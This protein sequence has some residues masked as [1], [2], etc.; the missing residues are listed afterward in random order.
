MLEWRSWIRAKGWDVGTIQHRLQ[1]VHLSRHLHWGTASRHCKIHCRRWNHCFSPSLAVYWSL[2]FT[3][4]LH[5]WSCMLAASS[6]SHSDNFQLYSWT[7]NKE[8]YASLK[9][10]YFLTSD[11]SLVQSKVG[12]FSQKASYNPGALADL[13]DGK[14]ISQFRKFRVLTAVLQISTAHPRD[15]WEIYI[16]ILR[17]KRSLSLLTSNS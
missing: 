7:R 13:W 2:D 10:K 14:A 5:T 16:A 12:R 6:H 1:I 11:V 3:T 8:S 9:F 4:P 15:Q 17:W